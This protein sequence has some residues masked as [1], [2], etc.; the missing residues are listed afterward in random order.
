MH[1]K[2]T[3]LLLLRSDHAVICFFQTPLL[4][5]ASESGAM[6]EVGKMNVSWLC[7]RFPFDNGMDADPVSAVWRFCQSCNV[8]S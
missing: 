5:K 7:S 2:C 1:D 8:E 4:Q 6:A 3:L